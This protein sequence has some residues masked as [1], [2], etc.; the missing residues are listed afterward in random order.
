MLSFISSL[1]NKTPYKTQVLLCINNIIHMT[2]FKKEAK[3]KK[4]QTNFNIMGV[5]SQIYGRL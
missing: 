5:I 3:D 1:I 2:V 4:R